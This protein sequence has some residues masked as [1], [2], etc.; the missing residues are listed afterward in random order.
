MNADQDCYL[1]LA[2]AFVRGRLIMSD[3]DFAAGALFATSL[4][5][6]STDQMRE[7]LRIGE[8]QGLRLHKFKRTIELPRVQRVLGILKGLQPGSLLDIGSGRG[9]FL[10]PLLD[11]FSWLPI[12]SVDLLDR[13]V[14][15]ILAVGRGG[16]EHLTTVKA[17]ATRLPFPAARF[18]VV[19]A[20]E[21][22]EHIPDAAAALAEIARV[23]QRAVVL[24]VP[25]HPDDNPEHIHLFDARTLTAILQQAGID[26]VNV[27]HVRNH[28]IVVGTHRR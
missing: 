25:S 8:A 10:W 5:I 19:T 21:V 4:D 1:R 28:M 26:R 16:I 14:E 15:D 23:A 12:T 13:R 22:L 18:D 11:S 2:A 6:L 17:D 3:G 9:A 27:T 20:L 24:S 7:L